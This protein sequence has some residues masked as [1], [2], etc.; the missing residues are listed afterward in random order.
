MKT[1]GKCNRCGKIVTSPHIRHKDRDHFHNSQDNLEVL[2]QDCHI[3]EHRNES[4]EHARHSM[5]AFT[6][7]KGSQLGYRLSRGWYME[8][9]FENDW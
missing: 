2:C 8:N 4:G 1:K 5:D 7:M 3:D 9:S 6:V